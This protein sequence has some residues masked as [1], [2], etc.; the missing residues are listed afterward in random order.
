MSC[1]FRLKDCGKCFSR[2]HHLKRHVSGVHRCE[3]SRTGTH[4]TYIVTKEDIDEEEENDEQVKY[5]QTSQKL[6]EAG[7]FCLHIKLT[8]HLN[9]YPSILHCS[10]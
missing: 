8:K 1:H 3:K 5:L 9:F 7:V 6:V 2:T 10:T 4:T